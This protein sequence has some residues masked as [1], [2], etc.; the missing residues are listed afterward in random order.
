MVYK[1]YLWKQ[2]VLVLSVC[3]TWAYE[4]LNLLEPHMCLI[5]KKEERSH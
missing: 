2:T 5:C 4:L 3:V 1:L